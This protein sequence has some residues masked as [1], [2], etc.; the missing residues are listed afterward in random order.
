[1]LFQSSREIFHKSWS[2]LQYQYQAPCYIY[3]Y[4]V[5]QFRYINTFSDIVAT[6]QDVDYILWIWIVDANIQTTRQDKTPPQPL[7]ADVICEQ[8]GIIDASK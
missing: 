4:Q 1:M 5:G 6:S 2:L 8:S 3:G 7:P